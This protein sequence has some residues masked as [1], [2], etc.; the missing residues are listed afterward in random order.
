[1]DNTIKDKNEN[2]SISNKNIQNNNSKPASPSPR[3]KPRSPKKKRGSTNYPKNF[4]LIAELEKSSE[5]KNIN[6]GIVRKN[7]MKNEITDDIVKEFDFDKTQFKYE[8]KRSGERRLKKK[9]PNNKKIVKK[10]VLVQK[11]KKDPNA[12]NKI[13]VVGKVSSKLTELIQKLTQSTSTKE[14]KPD[15][16]PIGDKV[17]VAPRI[18]AAVEKFNKRREERRPKLFHYGERSNK[19]SRTITSEKSNKS[20]ISL[21]EED[22][23]DDEEEEYEYE[24]F[25]EDEEFFEEDDDLEVNIDEMLDTYPQKRSRRTTKK[26]KSRKENENLEVNVDEMLD[27]YPQK[28]IRRTT[29]KKRRKKE[30]EN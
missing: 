15:P 1:M 16:N 7:S 5:D 20:S 28:R 21:D 11:K 18:K 19:K 2:E 30:N 25:E 17:V 26:G 3:K 24:E 12:T 8:R 14:R 6:N 4:S 23:F 22:E 29:K 10:K 9:D 27:T 13:R